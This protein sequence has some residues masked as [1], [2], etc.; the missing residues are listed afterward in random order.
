MP[1]R[2]PSN[3]HVRPYHRSGAHVVAKAAPYLVERVKDPSVPDDVLTPV[4]R[5]APDWRRQVL[6]DL[7]GLDAVSATKRALLDAATGS[8][9]LLA[10]LDAYVFELAGQGG[11][12]NRKHRRVFPVGA[13][14]HARG[15]GARASASSSRPRPRRAPARRP[16]PVLGPATACGLGPAR[17]PHG[18]SPPS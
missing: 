9:I 18:R 12:A 16:H 8:M 2:P 17:G 5:A 13:R 14:P 3:R 1:S 4:E 10:S 6:D 15:G 7:G 11:L